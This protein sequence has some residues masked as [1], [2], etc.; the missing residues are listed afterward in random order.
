MPSPIMTKRCSLEAIWRW[1]VVRIAPLRSPELLIYFRGINFRTRGL[2]NRLY[3]KFVLHLCSNYYLFPTRLW[4]DGICVL[5]ST[6][7]NIDFMSGIAGRK[8]S[9]GLKV[10]NCLS[11]FLS[12]NESHD[13]NFDFSRESLLSSGSVAEVV[14]SSRLHLQIFRQLRVPFFISDITGWATFGGTDDTCLNAMK[15]HIDYDR[16]LEVKLFIYLNDVLPGN[17]FQYLLNSHRYPLLISDSGTDDLSAY[18]GNTNTRIASYSGVAGTTL[19]SLN[20]GVHRDAPPSIL[21]LAKVVLQIQL[22]IEPFGLR[23]TKDIS[24]LFHVWN[25]Y[26]S[27]DIYK[28]AAVTSPYIFQLFSFC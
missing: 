22:G 5:S 17:G 28:R 11:S 19:L 6:S 24:N 10:F 23:H 26:G 21:G 14:C 7:H 12:S 9:D 8:R 3:S 27:F 15:W 20:W 13:A 2:F 1:L 18:S 25:S 4:T 16:M